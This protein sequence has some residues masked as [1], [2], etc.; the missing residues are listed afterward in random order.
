MLSQVCYDFDHN[1]L[2]QKHKSTTVRY[3]SEWLAVYYRTR[4]KSWQDE[5]LPRIQ[6]GEYQE[7]NISAKFR[8]KPRS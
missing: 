3:V 7:G 2:R 6:Q 4:Y 5:K 1:I 8:Q